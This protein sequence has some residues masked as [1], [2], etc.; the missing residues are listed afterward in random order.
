MLKVRMILFLIIIV[1]VG[2]SKN[3][4]KN[5]IKSYKEIVTDISK[6]DAE[7]K[8]NRDKRDQEGYVHTSYAP[9]C[10]ININAFTYKKI[11]DMKYQIILTEKP[12]KDYS[13]DGNLKWM[14]EISENNNLKET[15]ELEPLIDFNYVPENYRTSRPYMWKRVTLLYNLYNCG[16]FVFPK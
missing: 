15:K 2:C 4:E 8:K 16:Y 14:Y 13:M 1:L 3:E 6:A 10:P 7:M 5:N 11:D 9:E 12:K